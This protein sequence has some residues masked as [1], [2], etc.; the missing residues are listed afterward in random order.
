MGED[1]I[2]LDGR[3]ETDGCYGTGGHDKAI[4]EHEDMLFCGTEHR[5]DGGDHLEA[6]EITNRPKGEILLRLGLFIVGEGLGQHFTF[7]ADAWGVETSPSP[8]ALVEGDLSEETHPDTG[9]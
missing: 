4:D 2:V 5:P 9:G 8:N 7:M 1:H 6:A 3:V